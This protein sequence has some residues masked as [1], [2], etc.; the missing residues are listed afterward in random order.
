MTSRGQPAT[1]Q[2]YERRTCY[3]FDFLPVPA[4]RHRANQNYNQLFNS[5]GLTLFT[6]RYL[7]FVRPPAQIPPEVTCFRPWRPTF[8]EIACEIEDPS[9]KI[10]RG[11]L[12]VF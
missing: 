10:H 2:S 8:S 5:S 1:W 7:V 12:T 3:R 6:L 9:D 4:K 11:L